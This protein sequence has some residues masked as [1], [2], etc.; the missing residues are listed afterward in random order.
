M[1][2][3]RKTFLVIAMGTHINYF[4]LGWLLLLL[5]PITKL[6]RSCTTNLKDKE[7]IYCCEYTETTNLP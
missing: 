3:N 7:K 2:K 4:T 6:R 1:G 5:N